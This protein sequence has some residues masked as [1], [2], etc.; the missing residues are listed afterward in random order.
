VLTNLRSVDAA[1]A[2]ARKILQALDRPFVI[3]AQSAAVS[4]SIGVV[5]APDHGRDVEALTRRAD[6]AMYTAKGQRNG[7][8]IYEARQDNVSA[9]RL[10]LAADLKQA[11]QHGELALEFQPQVGFASGTSLEVETLLRWRHPIHGLVEPD[12]FV[13]LA[14][15][16]GLINELTD[17]VIDGALAQARTWLETGREIPVAVHISARSLH[18]PTL[19]LRVQRALHR[20]DIPPRLLKLELAER[21]VMEHGGRE[22]ET[23]ADLS[24]L[25]VVLCINGFGAGYSSLALLKRLPVAELKIDRSFTRNL[26]DD[27]RDAA[28]VRAIVDLGHNLGMSVA[29]DGIDDGPLAEKVAILGCDRGQGY[30][31][32]RVYDGES[33]R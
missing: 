28:M 31:F 10:S 29:A 8:A 4:G 13:P 17:W 27:E 16:A 3:D 12:R 23:L 6:V 5:V 19:R 21:T 26:L 25:G 11:M 32:G 24:S 20:H 1:A 22:L 14:E 15:R 2:V 18:D 9:E 7:Y 33:A 30:Y